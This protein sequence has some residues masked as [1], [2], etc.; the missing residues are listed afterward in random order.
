VCGKGN[1]K[2]DRANGWKVE[3]ESKAWRWWSPTWV[4]WPLFGKHTATALLW[5]VPPPRPFWGNPLTSDINLNSFLHHYE[6][7]EAS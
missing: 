4:F 1:C 3:K 6:S 7:E 2:A 5:T